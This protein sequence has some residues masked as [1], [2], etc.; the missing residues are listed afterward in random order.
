MQG[1]TA[2]EAC[3]YVNP[4]VAMDYFMLLRNNVMTRIL[5]PLMAV[6]TA[7]KMLATL[8][9]EQ[10]PL[11]LMNVIQLV[12]TALK[13]VMKNVMT[14]IFFQTMGV[15]LNVFMSFI[16]IALLIARE[17]VFVIFV[18]IIKQSFLLNFVMT[19]LQMKKDVIQI[20]KELIRDGI[21]KF[22]HNKKN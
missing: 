6:Q 9:H 3:Q 14:A 10:P 2:Q 22:I 8:V 16:K 4:F 15:L 20:V 11:P 12:E 5:S 7:L 13:P 21:A 17:R 1:I 18:G 19:E